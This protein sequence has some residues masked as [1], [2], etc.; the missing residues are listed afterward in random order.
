MPEETITFELIRKIQREEQR[1]P[2]L[3]KLPENFYQNVRNYIQQK[4]T[5]LEKMEDRRASVEIKNIESLVEDVFNRRE[6]KIMTQAVN[7]ARVGLTIE[8]LS[9]EEKEFLGHAVDL[10]KARRDKILKEIL[11]K[12]EEEMVP[13]IVFKEPVPEFVGADMKTYGP[14]QKGDIAKLPEENKKILLERGLAEE[15]KLSK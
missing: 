7:S 6:R 15:F 2:K 10:I 3:S 1:S 9:E 14:F 4:R 8:N 5:I 11:E 13:L 12:T